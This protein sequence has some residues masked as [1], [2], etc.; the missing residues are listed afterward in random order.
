M[1]DL[2]FPVPDPLWFISLW[3]IGFGYG[4]TFRSAWVLFKTAIR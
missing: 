2:I 3:V 1:I 4:V